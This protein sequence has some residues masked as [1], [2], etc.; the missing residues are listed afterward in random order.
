MLILET[1]R[2]TLRPVTAEDLPALYQLVYADEAVSYWWTNWPPITYERM[3]E[4]WAP[5]LN[6]P[7]GAFG[8]LV[9][10]RREDEELLGLV[11]LQRYAPG[12]TESYLVFDGRPNT[13]GQDPAFPECELT[14]AFGSAFW[15]QGYASEAC[16]A[17][18]A[19]GFD[20]LGLGRVINAVCSLN[21]PSIQ[22]MQRLGFRIE[23]NLHLKPYPHIDA[24][25]V[26]GI[27]ERPGSP[28]PPR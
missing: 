11:A 17:L 15:G 10:L 8:W 19:Y 12:E 9:A 23:R 20:T 5:R 6:L 14:Y 3:Q 18:L 1:E 16:R 2:L 21:A 26:V 28:S 7:D 25:G 24:P 27:L 22:L 4:R 13:V